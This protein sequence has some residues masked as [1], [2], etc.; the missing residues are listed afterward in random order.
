MHSSKRCHTFQVHNLYKQGT[1]AALAAV[2]AIT[3]GAG[4]GVAAAQDAAPPPPT[5]SS[6]P[7]S[8]MAPNAASDSSPNGANQPM[9]HQP[10]GGNGMAPMSDADFTKEAAQGGMAEVKMGQLAADKGTSD[11]VKAFGKQMVADHS[12]ANDDLKAAATQSNMTVPDGVSAKDK[13]MY[14]R[15]SKMSGSDFDQAYA[16]M[17]LRDHKHDIAAFRSESQ[18]GTDPNIKQFATQ[19][20]P[21]LQSHM[22][23]ARAMATAVGVQP[24]E[25]GG[26]GHRSAAQQPQMTPGDAQ[27]APQP[28]PQQ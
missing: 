26:P 13:M 5:P 20:L 15:L 23:Q 25:G 10:R 3:L 19:T 16:K 17:M 11:A 2:F 21:T 18:N 27:P 22:K 8:G 24:G 14:D 1:R 6:Q 9:R 28:A 12:K 4:A 7:D